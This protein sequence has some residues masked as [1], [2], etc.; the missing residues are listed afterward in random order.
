MAN[1]LLFALDVDD[2]NLATTEREYGN[3]P[4]GEHTVYIYHANGCVNPVEFELDEYSPLTLEADKTGPNEITARAEGGFGGYTFY[5]QGETFGSQ[6]VFTVSRDME[7]TIMVEDSQGCVATLVMPFDFEAMPDL[8]DYFSPNGDNLNEEWFVNN[9]DVFASLDVKIYDR[10][11][12]VVAELKEV[13]KWDGTYNGS[14]LPT[15]DYWYVVTVNGD[16]SQRYVGHFT[17][18]R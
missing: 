15:G 11:G 14:A 12:R 7:I 18:Y 9:A 8:P 17:L 5:F 1:Q 3:L 6:N 10:Y 13:K 4:P 16:A 2:I